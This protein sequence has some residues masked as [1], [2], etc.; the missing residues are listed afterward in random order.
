LRVGGTTR[1]PSEILAHLCDLFDWSLS[2][3]RGEHVWRDSTAGPWDSDVQR[4]FEGLAGLINRRPR[5]VALLVLALFLLGLI[6][7]IFAILF[8]IYPIQA[9]VGVGVLVG[10]YF[11]IS[12]LV[13]IYTGFQVRS[14]KSWLSGNPS[15]FSYLVTPGAASLPLYL[16]S[17]FRRQEVWYWPTL[18]K[19]TILI[20]FLPIFHGDFARRIHRSGL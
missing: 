1:T 19:R 3:V 9:A 15:P 13:A 14:L 18:K 6:A 7:I 5:L 16:R 8:F 12:G 11:I 2:L 17:G 4:F 10:I 20:R